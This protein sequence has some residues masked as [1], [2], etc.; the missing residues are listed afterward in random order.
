MDQ[1]K[2]S[3]EC[4]V[5]GAPAGPEVDGGPPVPTCACNEGYFAQLAATV[6]GEGG[7]Q[8]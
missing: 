7:V 4:R 3:F 6:T 8:S 5:C 1:P 2:T